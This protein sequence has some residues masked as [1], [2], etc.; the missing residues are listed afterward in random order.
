MN[1]TAYTAYKRRA[2]GHRLA[3]S[4]GSPRNHTV[5]A[6]AWTRSMPAPM[7]LHMGCALQERDPAM[8]W[9][10]DTEGVMLDGA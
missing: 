4:S 8:P 1:R 6:S 2:R 3:K 9:L 5:M 7:A 10:P